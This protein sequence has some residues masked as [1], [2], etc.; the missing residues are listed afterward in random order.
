ML[1]DSVAELAL[2]I[3]G[4]DASTWELKLSALL[5]FLCKPVCQRLKQIRIVILKQSDDNDAFTRAVEHYIQSL[6]DEGRRLKEKTR[7]LRAFLESC[8]EYKR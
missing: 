3:F 2:E 8:Q 7:G 4:A 6:R 1:D 5:L